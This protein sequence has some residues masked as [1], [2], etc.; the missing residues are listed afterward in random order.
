MRIPVR[1]M[2][3]RLNDTPG[4]RASLGQAYFYTG[5]LKE[6]KKEI[7]SAIAG[8]HNADSNNPTRQLGN[9]LDSHVLLAEIYYNEGNNK[10]AV[11]ELKTINT[12]LKDKHDPQVQFVVLGMILVALEEDESL[13]PKA[14]VKFRKRT[15]VPKDIKTQF[16][17]FQDDFKKGRYDS[18]R[19]K[20]TTL[21]AMLEKEKG[22]YVRN[23]EN[24]R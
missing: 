12:L 1:K 4:N 19:E 18:A 7:L 23:T 11:E 22:D 13:D 17:K 20:L 8:E 5:H 6:A 24:R 10:L 2:L 15:S 16:D 21:L 9:I 14:N 3:V